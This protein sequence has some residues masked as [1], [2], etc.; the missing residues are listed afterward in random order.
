[1]PGSETLRYS[2]SQC[3][4]QH[5]RIAA[6][7]RVVASSRQCRRQPILRD[8]HAPLASNFLMPNATFLVLFLV[9]LVVFGLLVI[10]PLVETVVRQQWGYT[11]GVVLLGPIGGL[12]WFFVGRRAT[13]RQ[14]QRN[15]ESRMRVTNSG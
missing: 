15:N 14:R 11:L 10:W 6:C 2:A 1:M 12:L 7:E 9:S 13:A 5:A 4:L 8:M 3:L